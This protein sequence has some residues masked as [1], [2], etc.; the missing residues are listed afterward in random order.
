[1]PW[2]QRARPYWYHSTLVADLCFQYLSATRAVIFRVSGVHLDQDLE[3]LRFDLSIGRNELNWALASIIDSPSFVFIDRVTGQRN[4][5]HLTHPDPPLTESK[6]LTPGNSASYRLDELASR[7]S[8]DPCLE[9]SQPSARYPIFLISCNLRE[10]D[11]KA[12]TE[13]SGGMLTDK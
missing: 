10:R 12:Q 8:F 4:E 13:L 3:Y 2:L 6:S 7:K 1:M 5:T 9:P 11:W